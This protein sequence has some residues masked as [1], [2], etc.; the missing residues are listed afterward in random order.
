MGW[1]LEA[2][3][4]KTLVAIASDHGFVP[5]RRQVHLNAWL[6]NEGYA[7]LRK[8]A[9]RGATSYFDDT[10]WGATKAYGLGINGLYLNVKGREPDG[11][12][13][14]GSDY[15]A[16]RTEL[17]ER[18]L[19]FRDPATGERVMHRVER[20]EDLYQGPFANRAPDL[21]ALYGKHYRA[22]WRTILGAYD[23]DTVT[24]NLDPW[25]GD[26]CM[27]SSFLSGVFLCNRPV[28]VTDPH[29]EDLAPSF[30]DLCRVDI[31]A[32]MTGRKIFHAR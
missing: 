28:T 30:L 11:I 12:V 6:A 3:G 4:D 21:I 15:E 23:K 18:L 10:E 5:F 17:R 14:P 1:V 2:A 29:L 7:T 27:D 9:T 16:T 26:H 24:D 8:G 19:A 20:W 32:E 31:P 25:S 13:A 22:S